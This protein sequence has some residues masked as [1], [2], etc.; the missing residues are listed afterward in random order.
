ML[1]LNNILHKQRLLMTNNRKTRILV[2]GAS[3]SI[4]SQLVK[5]LSNS[6]AN[7]RVGVHSKDRKNKL[8]KFNGGDFV[9]IDYDKSDT[10]SR[11]CTDVDR[12]FLLISGP[13]ALEH[14]S[15]FVNETLKINFQAFTLKVYPFL[16][17][18]AYTLIPM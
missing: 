1:D 7:F 4:G 14:V 17:H 16:S 13:L 6:K 9:E 18:Y 15:K 8:S 10:I 3:G 2:T 5:Q 12:V 11:A